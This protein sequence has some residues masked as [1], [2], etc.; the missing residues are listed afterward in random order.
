MRGHRACPGKLAG[1]L[2][3]GVVVASPAC[4]EACAIGCGCLVAASPLVG[5]HTDPR[6]TPTCSVQLVLFLDPGGIIQGGPL[7]LGKGIWAC[8]YFP[9]NTGLGGRTSSPAG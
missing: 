5:D 4:G 2:L 1:G 9:R 3:L 8:K 7:C 6:K